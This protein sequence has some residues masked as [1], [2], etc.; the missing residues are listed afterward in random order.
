MPTLLVTFV[1]AKY[2]LATF[3]YICN[4]LAVTDLT[5]MKL[6]REHLEQNPIVMVTLVQAT[7]VVD[8]GCAPLQQIYTNLCFLL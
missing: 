3:V 5:L 6:Q 2:V 7:F 4:I 8:K 1:Q